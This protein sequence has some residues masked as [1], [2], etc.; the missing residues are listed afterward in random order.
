M[1]L[2]L[3]SGGR[4][5]VDPLLNPNVGRGG[6]V[7]TLAQES[8]LELRRLS[9]DRRYTLSNEPPLGNHGGENPCGLH[10][11]SGHRWPHGELTQALVNLETDH[12][13]GYKQI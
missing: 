2:R 9:P 4:E 5:T 6:R 12:H 10:G 1:E 8:C 11:P 3:R 7:Q 13:Y